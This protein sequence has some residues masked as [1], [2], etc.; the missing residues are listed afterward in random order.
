[1]NFCF[2]SLSW[3]KYGAK[4]LWSFYQDFG[5][6]CPFLIQPWRPG[7]HRE[8]HIGKRNCF[9]AVH[10]WSAPKAAEVG[11]S[12]F[13][14]LIQNQLSWEKSL[15]QVLKS[16]SRTLSCSPAAGGAQNWSLQRPGKCF[17][18]WGSQESGFCVSSGRSPA[19]A[20]GRLQAV[21]GLHLQAEPH[22]ECKSRCP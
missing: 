7:L 17:P 21:P 9:D 1:M 3:E 22:Q 18:T 19:S 12:L 8:R 20:P 13:S 15:G 2:N 4:H 16:L 10:L 6:R 5:I 14:L 11:H